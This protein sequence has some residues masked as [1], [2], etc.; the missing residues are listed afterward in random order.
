LASLA[1]AAHGRRRMSKTHEL[2]ALTGARGIAA[3]LVVL[4]HLRFMMAGIGGATGPLSYG[5]LAVDFF[6][7]LSGFVIWL[8]YGER[9]REQGIACIPEFLKRRVARVWPLH[10]F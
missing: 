7:V 1:K 9:L 4:F 5:Y 8:T 10:L 2:K 3:W 6:F